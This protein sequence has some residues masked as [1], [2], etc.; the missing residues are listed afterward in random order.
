MKY[1]AFLLVASLALTS[2]ALA[3]EASN[4][5]APQGTQEIRP[6]R[7]AL[8]EDQKEQMKERHDQ[9]HERRELRRE[10]RQDRHPERP[11]GQ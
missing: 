1:A 5:A 8:N 10:R 4:T 3:E 9:R 2:P 6:D 7:P 11:P